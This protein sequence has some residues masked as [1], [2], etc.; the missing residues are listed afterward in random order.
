MNFLRKHFHPGDKSEWEGGKRP[1]PVLYAVVSV[2]AGIAGVMMIAGMLM[3]M[4]PFLLAAAVVA[5]LSS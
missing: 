4:W 3:K 2:V 5:L 1:N